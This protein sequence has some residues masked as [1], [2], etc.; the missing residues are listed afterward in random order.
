MQKIDDR[1]LCLFEVLHLVD[2]TEPKED[3]HSE[4]T[5]LFEVDLVSNDTES[6]IAES[7]DE[8]EIEHADLSLEG[9]DESPLDIKVEQP[10]ETESIESSELNEIDTEDLM[11]SVTLPDNIDQIL[12][13]TDEDSTQNNP[14][15]SDFDYNAYNAVDFEDKQELKLNS[16]IYD[17]YDL[18]VTADSKPEVVKTSE[19]KVEDT[20]N[21]E[22][23]ITKSED[24]VKSEEVTLSNEA[25]ESLT[26]VGDIELI[27]KVDAVVTKDISNPYDISNTPEILSEDTYEEESKE[28]IGYTIS[29]ALKDLES[30]V[31]TSEP[32]EEDSEE[33]KEAKLYLE[34]LILQ[35]GIQVGNKQITKKSMYDFG[36][37]FESNIS[38]DLDDDWIDDEEELEEIQ[39]IQEEPEE[40]TAKPKSG[41]FNKRKRGK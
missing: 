12:E 21:N 29:S 37:D 18:S 34:T 26:T 19:T 32:I 35:E 14:N 36:Y 30:F 16:N 28:L 27:N 2:L 7:S 13:E 33:Y 11:K 25:Q 31:D 22:V 40:P 8:T 24:G 6:Q 39:P 4:I 1:L 10:R 15:V 9:L 5:A 3:N 20:T 38:I 41:L 17:S 23:I